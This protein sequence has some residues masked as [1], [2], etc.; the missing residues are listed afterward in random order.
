MP[1]DPEITKTIV[2]RLG[3]FRCPWVTV[4]DVATGAIK[5]SSAVLEVGDRICDD[6]P[7]LLQEWRERPPESRVCRGAPCTIQ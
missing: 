6:A 2:R 5:S 3:A 1:Y 4:M 7:K